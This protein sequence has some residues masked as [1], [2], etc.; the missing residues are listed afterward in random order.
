MGQEKAISYVVKQL[1]LFRSKDNI[2]KT[3]ATSG[4]FDYYQARQFVRYVEINHARKVA[5]ARLPFVLAIGIP[6]FLVGFVITIALFA[7]IY[8]GNLSARAIIYGIAGIGILVGSSWGMLSVVSKL[9]R[10]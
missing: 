1:G 9:L 8:Y 6:G 7:N 10:G 2:A 4:Q 5:M 3:L